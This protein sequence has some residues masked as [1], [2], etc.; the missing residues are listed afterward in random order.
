MRKAYERLIVGSILDSDCTPDAVNTM[1][2][3]MGN[4]A[5]GDKASP[6]QGF[7]EDLGRVA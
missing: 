6:D 4:A 7:L 2:I 1:A 3:A 5:H